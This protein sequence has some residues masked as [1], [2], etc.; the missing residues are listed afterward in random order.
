MHSI[1]IRPARRRLVAAMT[2]AAVVLSAC[3]GGDVVDGVASLDDSGATTEAPVEEPAADTEQALI[4]FAACMREHGIELEDPTVDAD[5]N[6]QFGRLGVDRAQPGDTE[7]DRDAVREA[8]DVCGAMLDGITLGVR[9]SADPEFQDALVDFAA[10]MRDEGI[11]MD[12]PTFGGPGET[13]A[14]GAAGV[15]PFGALDR[16]DPAFVAAL[17]VCGDIV[18]AFGPGGGPPGGAD[19]G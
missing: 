11:E 2:V 8:R 3:G 16:D 6:V 19:E 9:R 15:G 14:D 5:G 12:D 10:C 7:F 1:Q 13:G 18:G 17:E 4:A